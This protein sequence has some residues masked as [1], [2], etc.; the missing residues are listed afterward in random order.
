MSAG[1]A[2]EPTNR[3][4][5]ICDGNT[6]MAVDIGCATKSSIRAIYQPQSRLIWP[7]RSDVV[8]VTRARDEL[9]ICVLAVAA[10]ASPSRCCRFTSTAVR[11]ADAETWREGDLIVS[12]TRARRL[13][14]SSSDRHVYDHLADPTHCLRIAI[15]ETMRR[16][17]GDWS[18]PSRGIRASKYYG[19]STSPPTWARRSTLRLR[20]PWQQQRGSTVCCDEYFPKGTSLRHHADHLRAV[21]CRCAGPTPSPQTLGMNFSPRC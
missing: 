13:A 7:R 10:R 8:T 21:E 5:G 20:S 17:A 18:G 1:P 4:P 9:I 16:L 6:P 2:V 12:R 15:A 3:S 11:S 14:P 19:T